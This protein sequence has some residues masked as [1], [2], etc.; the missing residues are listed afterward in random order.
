MTPE[1]LKVFLEEVD[2]GYLIGALWLCTPRLHPALSRI[3]TFH[4][5]YRKAQQYG[6]PSMIKYLPV[7]KKVS[8]IA[9]YKSGRAYITGDGAVKNSRYSDIGPQVEDLTLIIRDPYGRKFFD[10]PIANKNLWPNLRHCNISLT[11]ETKVLEQWGCHEKIETIKGDWSDSDLVLPTVTVIDCNIAPRNTPNVVV[12]EGYTCYPLEDLPASLTRY[13]DGYRNFVGTFH[14]DLEFPLTLSTRD[15]VSG[16]LTLWFSSLQSFGIDCSFIQLGKLS[17][18]VSRL[19]HTLEKLVLKNVGS[20]GTSELP[21]VMWPPSLTHLGLSFSTKLTITPK[22][23]T[24]LPTTLTYLKI[25]HNN[26]SLIKDDDMCYLPPALRCVSL[27]NTSNVIKSFLD[28]SIRQ[29]S[30]RELKLDTDLINYNFPV[31]ITRLHLIFR[32]FKAM[33]L[34]ALYGLTECILS[35][36]DVIVYPCVLFPSQLRKLTLQQAHFTGFCSVPLPDSIRSI[37]LRCTEPN[38][39][40]HIYDFLHFPQ[41]LLK[42][43]ASYS[44]PLRITTR[45]R[46]R[47]PPDAQLKN[48]LVD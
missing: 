34:R 39:L 1:F 20:F 15:L 29:R 46:E 45:C 2:D 3:T 19:P 25:T 7:L 32:H 6:W 13:D 27:C 36:C 8:I 14:H 44:F 22:V 11:L 43:K 12:R 23:L 41:M 10:D 35:S 21:D 17:V 18:F 31:G 40:N 24:C 30:L 28:N 47:M 4:L 9:S 16:N 26:T 42:L 38:S 48:I 5:K 33:N 37:T